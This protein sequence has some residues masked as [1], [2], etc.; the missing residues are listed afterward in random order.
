MSGQNPYAELMRL[1]N[2]Y[3]VSQAI[4]VAATLGIADLLGDEPRDSDDIAAKAGVHPGSLYR[5][6]R[7]LAAA[8]VFHED[9]DRRFSLTAIGQCLRSDA[10]RTLG[11]W[12]EFVGR[13]YQWSAWGDLLHGVQTGETPF[14]HVHGADPWEYRSRHPEEGAIF[15]RAM[16]GMSRRMTQATVAAYD[17]SR[18]RCVIDVGGGHG[19]LLAAVLAAHPSVRGVLFDQPGVVA[20][21]A[22]VLREAGVADRC[23]VVG[24][25][26]FERVPEGGDAYLLKTVLHD[27]DDAEARAILQACRRFIGPEGKL[28]VLERLVAPPNEDLEAKFFDLFMMTVTGGR[29]RAR[30]EFATLLADAGFRLDAVTRTGTPIC[31]IEAAPI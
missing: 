3:Q 31:I 8:G 15:D 14:R 30:E 25:N 11:P 16:T 26:F 29:E 21:A 10:D 19:A 5:L 24:G 12:A 23:E 4:Y 6:L 28:L 13:P 20:G 18:F 27:W 22:A 9:A 1:T 17:F 2:G 7:A